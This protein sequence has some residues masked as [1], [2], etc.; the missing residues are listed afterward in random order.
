MFSSGC[1]EYS[2]PEHVREHLDIIK[3]TVHFA[4]R[5]TPRN[6]VKRSF[7][8]IGM[9][10]TT[11]QGGPKTNGNLVKITPVLE[12]CDEAITPD[13][14]RALYSINYT[15]VATHKNSFGIGECDTVWV[16][17]TELY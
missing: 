13:C 8:R 6:P 1:H 3:P 7:E 17:T 9:P 4:Q 16:T 2:V 11:F 15:P 12:N 5:L 10:G 14:L